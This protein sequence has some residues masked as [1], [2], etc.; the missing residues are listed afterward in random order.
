MQYADVNGIK[1]S[2]SPNLKGKCF[3]CD[4]EVI[5]KCG[6]FKIWHWAHKDLKS[7]DPWWENETEWHRQWKN[8][9]PKEN[10]EIVHFDQKTGEK[11]IADVKTNNGVVIEFQ[12]SPMSI[13]ELESRESFYGNM[14][15]IINGSK[16]K[17]R[18]FIYDKLPKPD[19]RPHKE[20]IFFRRTDKHA[21]AFYSKA[22]NYRKNN[23]YEVH[24]IKEI[25]REIE[26]EYDGHHLYHWSNP[27]KVWYN[28]SKKIFIDLG[29]DELIE[30][31]KYAHNLYCIKKWNKEYFINRAINPTK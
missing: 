28:S 25:E 20:N 11:H 16:F 15:W 8:Y 4:S 26:E 6:S 13:E 14:I 30:L 24:G 3:C 21:G 23:L 12:N 17:N 18:F 9:F 5:A 31:L 7:C 27:K 29:G 1:S 19:S 22:K 2:P 10:Q